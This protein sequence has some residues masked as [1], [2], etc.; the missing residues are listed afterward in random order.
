MTEYKFS[1]KDWSWRLARMQQA[2]A[3][4]PDFFSEWERSFILS[5]NNMIRPSE[6]QAAI[7]DKIWEKVKRR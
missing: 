5:Q 6:K 7:Q 2:A 3:I 1:E 4:D